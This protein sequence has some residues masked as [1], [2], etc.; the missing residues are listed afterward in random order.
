MHGRCMG[1]GRKEGAARE[2][3]HPYPYAVPTTPYPYPVPLPPS[4][5]PLVLAQ[6]AAA[7]AALGRRA[8]SSTAKSHISQTVPT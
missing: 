8:A 3:N 6:G 2:A 1:D 7:R 4:V 5:L